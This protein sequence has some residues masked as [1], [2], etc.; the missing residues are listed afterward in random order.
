VGGVGPAAGQTFEQ[1]GGAVTIQFKGISHLVGSERSVS[2]LVEDTKPYPGGNKAA[3]NSSHLGR[4]RRGVNARREAVAFGVV[5][6]SQ[7]RMRGGILQYGVGGSNWGG[8]IGSIT[9]ESLTSAARQV[10]QWLGIV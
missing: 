1:D 6:R 7:G 2:Q 9:G 10:S 3:D 8:C 5:V 4:H